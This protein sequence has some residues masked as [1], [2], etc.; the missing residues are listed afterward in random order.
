MGTEAQAMAPN[1]SLGSEQAEN[2]GV[3]F[4]IEHVDD[5]VVDHVNKAHE[6]L[7]AK[8]FANAMLELQKAL[9]DSPQDYEAAYLLGNLA[10]NTKKHEMAVDA[11]ELAATID[12]QVE[13][14]WIQL[15]RMHL[16]Q[17]EPDQAHKLI[18]QALERNPQ[19]AISH[20]VLGRIWL[21]RSHWDRAVLSFEKALRL[22]PDNEYFRNN[23]GFTL[24]LA[25]SYQRALAVLQPFEERDDLPAFMH[26]NLGL[27]YEGSGQFLDAIAAFEQSLEINP[28]YVNARLNLDRLLQLAQNEP[29]WQ[30]DQ[31]ID[32]DEVVDEALI[33]P[34][35]NEI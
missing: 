7:Q 35:D 31:P 1:P 33:L 13:D 5:Q 2:S 20:N 14:P 21:S 16:Q 11:Y 12:P 18:R 22:A 28:K 25:H 3:V 29:S 9:F 23:L 15:A 34:D 27:A 24:I 8:K 10:W 17:Q 32:V 4:A 30:Q 26:N 19:R 6:L